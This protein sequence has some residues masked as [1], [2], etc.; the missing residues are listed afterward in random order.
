MVCWEDGRVDD[1]FWIYCQFVAPF[2][3]LELVRF[4]ALP[5]IQDGAKCG[6]IAHIEFVVGAGG[7]KVIFLSTQNSLCYVDLGGGGN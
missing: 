4:S 7:G 6:N 5:R 2:C 3:K 1:A